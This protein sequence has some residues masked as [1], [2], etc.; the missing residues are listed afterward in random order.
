M[1]LHPEGGAI[2][3]FTTSRVV[4]TNTDPNAYNFGLNIQL[5]LAMLSP[6]ADGSP[7]TFGDI[8]RQTKNT[9]VGASFNS[10]KFV[11]IG[12]PATRIGL[13]ES[14][15]RLAS[16]NGTTVGSDPLQLRAL[17]EAILEG[18]VMSSDGSVNTSFNGQATVKVYD[19]TRFVPM[20][21]LTNCN[22]RDCAY[23][24]Q[25]DVVF[26]GKVSVTDGRFSSR[27]ILPRDIS[28]SDSTARV[29]M[30]AAGD[31]SDASGSFSN[32]ILNGRN[33]DAID[34]QTG[35]QLR[36]FL[37]DEDFMEGGIVNGNPVL[38]VDIEDASGINTAG[39]GVGHELI[40]I[41]RRRPAVGLEQTFMLNEFYESALNDYTQGRVRY[42]LQDLAPGTYELTLRAWDVFN[43]PGE[44][45]VTFDVV[46]QQ[47]LSV[48]NVFNY[49]NPTSG[50]TRFIFEHNQS[51]SSL[52]VL[53]R[54]FTLSG[55]P[56]AQLRE[57]NLSVSGGLASMEWDGTDAD[58]NRLASGTYLYHVKVSTDSATRETVEKLVIIR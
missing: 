18:D 37:N 51:G 39:A 3:A 29:V 49:P 48:R 22:I 21:Q 19:A 55:K 53:I 23:G 24:V 2:A 47:T 25:N 38:L 54:V 46:E 7:K 12:D 40:A 30:Y 32:L 8:Y 14:R 45:T 4:F 44:S 56:V 58:G 15:I 26:S 43:N 28:Y 11:L 9:T 41:L 16:I 17:D 35:P 5:T 33:P 1:V 52:D 36:I 57:R 50:Y 6:N 27:F 31:N 13:P 20:S 42:P 10:R 34:D